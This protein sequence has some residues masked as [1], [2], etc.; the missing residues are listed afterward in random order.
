MQNGTTIFEN[1]VQV[2]H[3]D[4]GY[5]DYYHMM[6]RDIREMGIEMSLDLCDESI[7]VVSPEES[8]CRIR[9]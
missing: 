9:M 6:R 8:L 3:H 4:L 1:T 2:S 7:E 5:A